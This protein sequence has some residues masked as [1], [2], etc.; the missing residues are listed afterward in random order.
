MRFVPVA[1]A[2][3]A[4][5]IESLRKYLRTTPTRTAWCLAQKAVI[6]IDPIEQ[7]GQVVWPARQDLVSS[8]RILTLQIARRNS[9]KDVFT[10][11]RV[12][13]R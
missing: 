4:P 13:V 9:H 3:G 8:L 7:Q 11:V 5:V 6:I 1:H 12:S 2:A 10:A